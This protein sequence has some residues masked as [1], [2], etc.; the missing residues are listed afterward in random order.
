MSQTIRCVPWIRTDV[1][2]TSTSG[3]A[4]WGASSPRSGRGT[5]T[6]LFTRPKKGRAHARSPIHPPTQHTHT[7]CRC[8]LGAPSSP[9][10]PCARERKR[11]R[12]SRMRLPFSG[13]RS[14]G[15]GCRE[16]KSPS[17]PPAESVVHA[18]ASLDRWGLVD[19]DP[20][21]GQ[22]SFC[23]GPGPPVQWDH[24]AP[25]WTI[26]FDLS[27]ASGEGSYRETQSHRRIDTF[28]LVCSPHADPFLFTCR[29]SLLLTKALH[30]RPLSPSLALHPP[31]PINR[32]GSS[33]SCSEEDLRR[34]HHP[35]QRSQYMNS[36]PCR[37]SRI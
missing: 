19:V 3:R 12:E 24:A 23:A 4:V 30:H 26:R 20:A 16:A 25:S 6:M 8:A 17:T 36:H 29:S 9:A 14:L 32:F 22:P 21:Q 5:T 37:S 2:R 7:P 18:C 34:A 27:S 28:P 10:R 35:A 11:E 31:L 1:Q 33:L 13:P 15:V